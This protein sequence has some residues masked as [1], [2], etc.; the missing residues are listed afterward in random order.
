MFLWSHPIYSF[1]AELSVVFGT[2]KVQVQSINAFTTNKNEITKDRNQE[3]TD[4]F[5]YRRYEF[6]A[7]PTLHSCDLPSSKTNVD[8]LLKI[9]DRLN[10]FKIQLLS[11]LGMGMKEFET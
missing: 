9:P 1:G 6:L 2:Y 8:I 5:W 7:N 3:L 10:V 4:Q 11:I